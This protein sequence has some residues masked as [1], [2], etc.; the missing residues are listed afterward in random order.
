VGDS[1][2]AGRLVYSFLSHTTGG[3]LLNFL[4]TTGEKRSHIEKFILVLFLLFHFFFL[5]LKR[6]NLTK[7]DEH[8][9]L[10]FFYLYT[11]VYLIMLSVNSLQYF[12]SIWSNSFATI[13]GVSLNIPLSSLA[14]KRFNISSNDLL[15]DSDSVF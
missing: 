4:S 15:N 3:I 14:D 7:N 10:A 12:P 8:S 13:S 6:D 5:F 1:F 9:H 2:F 11:I